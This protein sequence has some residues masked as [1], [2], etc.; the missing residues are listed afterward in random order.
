[1]SPF[2]LRGSEHVYVVCSGNLVA[3]FVAQPASSSGRSSSAD[4]TVLVEGTTI[5]ALVE[6]NGPLDGASSGSLAAGSEPDLGTSYSPH[7]PAA[8]VP[9]DLLHIGERRICLAVWH[10]FNPE[11]RSLPGEVADVQSAVDDL[12]RD[13]DSWCVG[14]SSEPGT[15]QLDRDRDRDPA[16]VAAETDQATA[17]TWPPARYNCGLRRTVGLTAL[18]RLRTGAG[19]LSR[20]ETLVRW[21]SCSQLKV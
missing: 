6:A 20:P 8:W 14:W 19:A 11:A 17:L 12:S 13:S 5:E 9:C 7:G 4:W 1:L 10:S 16:A 2:S 15:R 21:R 18:L 3:P